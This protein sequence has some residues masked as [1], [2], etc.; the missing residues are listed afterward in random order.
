[1]LA[2]RRRRRAADLRRQVHDLRRAAAVRRRPCRLRRS[3]ASRPRPH[4]PRRVGAGV[5]LVQPAGA[6]RDA[7]RGRHGRHP[8]VGPP[9]PD[10]RVAGQL[11]GRPRHLE[12]R[13][14]RAALGD[15]FA[16]RD[17]GEQWERPFY[18]RGTATE[19]QIEGGDA[20]GGR[21]RGCSTD[22]SPE[23]VEFLRGV[24]AGA[25]LRRARAVVRARDDRPRLP[26]GHGGDLRVPP[27][28]D[29]AALRAV[30]RALRDGPRAPPRGVPDRAGARRVPAEDERGSRRGAIW[31]GSRPRPTGAR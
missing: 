5:R 25:R 28:G 17:P 31:S 1:M 15:W 3:S 6:A 21:A 24:P 20:L 14:D 27:G 30:D 11:R 10:P 29:E 18:Q 26:V 12:R 7:V 9:P 23:W 16:F 22:F 8:A 2:A 4:R 13:L 19:Q